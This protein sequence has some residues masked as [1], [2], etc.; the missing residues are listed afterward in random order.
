[1]RSRSAKYEQNTTGFVHSEHAGKTTALVNKARGFH[2]PYAYETIGRSCEDAEVTQRKEATMDAT[3]AAK[4]TAT[5]SPRI[6]I[7]VQ[8]FTAVATKKGAA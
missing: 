1:M 4:T 3:H 6:T 7:G 2:L 5:S 8:S